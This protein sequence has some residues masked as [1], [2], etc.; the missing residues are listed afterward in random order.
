VEGPAVHIRSIEPE[1]K[2][3]PPFVIPTEA[4]RS[5]VLLIHKPMLTE[6]ASPPFVIPTEA[7]P[8][9]LPRSTGQVRVCAFL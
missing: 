2:R 3:N 4:E 9:F 8:D 1:W 6:S 7:Y 5:A